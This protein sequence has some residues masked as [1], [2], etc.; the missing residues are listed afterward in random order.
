MG[1]G[2]AFLEGHLHPGRAVVRVAARF[3]GGVNM[4]NEMR[5]Q[6]ILGKRL[7]KAIKFGESLDR[8]LQRSVESCKTNGDTLKTTMCSLIKRMDNP[9][10]DSRAC[11]HI[12]PILRI[13]RVTAVAKNSRKDF[14]FRT[15]F[16]QP[17][18]M[19]ILVRHRLN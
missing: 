7:V 14:R 19:S 17:K 5:Q 8:T 15:Y 3:S 1:C 11:G 10:G 16:G 6:M 13:S 12:L 2:E 18:W 9:L 4:R